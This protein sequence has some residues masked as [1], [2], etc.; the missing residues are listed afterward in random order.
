MFFTGI[1]FILLEGLFPKLW[2]IAIQVFD[3]EKMMAMLQLNGDI[4]IRILATRLISVIFIDLSAS[5]GTEILAINSL[6]FQSLVLV[7]L[8]TEGVSHATETLTGNLWG[9]NL[10]QQLPGLLRLSSVSGIVLGL[11]GIAP[12]ILFPHFLFS[13]FTDHNEIID[14]M[15]VYLLWLIPFTFASSLFNVLRGYW[16]GLTESKV[17]LLYTSDAADD[18]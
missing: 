18:W 11:V 12:F 3:R 13:L 4:T 7:S 14:G 15:G 8:M 2:S 1:I 17:C 5:F 16:L 9:Q 6:L 10:I